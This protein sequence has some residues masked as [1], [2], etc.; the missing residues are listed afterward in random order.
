[1]DYPSNYLTFMADKWQLGLFILENDEEGD[2][3]A[4]NECFTVEVDLLT[5]DSSVASNP[6]FTYDVACQVYRQYVAGDPPAAQSIVTAKL[7]YIEDI[8]DPSLRRA[9]YKSIQRVN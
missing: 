2:K 9:F 7:H 1:M 3:Y 6:V 5:V 4:P 8:N